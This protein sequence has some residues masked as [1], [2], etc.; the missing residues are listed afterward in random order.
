M[1]YHL[2]T[3]EPLPEPMLFLSFEHLGQTSGKSESKYKH[4]LYKGI[5]LLWNIGHLVKASM[6]DY[7]S[8]S[9]VCHALLVCQALV[10]M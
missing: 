3:A 6:S 8:E 4:L 7:A 10:I 1:A 9:V 2:L 5:G